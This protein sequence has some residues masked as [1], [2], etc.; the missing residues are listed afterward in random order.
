MATPG[1]LHAVLIATHSL[2]KKKDIISLKTGQRLMSEMD[3]GLKSLYFSSLKQQAEKDLDSVCKLA[4]R[5]DQVNETIFEFSFFVLYLRRF[6]FCF[7]CYDCS[8]VA[9]SKGVRVYLELAS[10]V[11]IL[12]SPESLLKGTFHP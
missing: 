2:K 11:R 12:S 7:K 3:S 8:T 6:S 4:I 5:V 10:R 9:S 1:T